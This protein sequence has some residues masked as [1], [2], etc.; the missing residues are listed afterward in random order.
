METTDFPFDRTKL[1]TLEYESLIPLYELR[2][3]E[4]AD[5]I[6]AIYWLGHA[7]TRV[8]RC[9]DGLSMDLRLSRLM[10]DDPT[11]QYNLGCS[12]AL[13]G[14][15]DEAFE[16]LSRAVSLG[17]RDVELLIADADLDSIR[18]DDRFGE[19]LGRLRDPTG[20]E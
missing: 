7:Y 15:A 4:E 12:F 16:T 2:L 19:L 6:P 5:D 10:P 14:R 8:G 17:Y 20:S 13:T 1:E 11:V 9:E 18:D 3:Q